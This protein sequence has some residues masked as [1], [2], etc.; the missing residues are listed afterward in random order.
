[1]VIPQSLVADLCLAI[2]VHSKNVSFTYFNE[3]AI[4]FVLIF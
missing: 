3:D 2:K 1:M 4:I